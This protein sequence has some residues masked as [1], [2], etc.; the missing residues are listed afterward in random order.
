VDNKP[1]LVVGVNSEFRYLGI[2][3]SLEMDNGT[4][5][6]LI[7]NKLK[8]SLIITS[9]LMIRPQQ[10]L[11]LLK[12]IMYSQLFSEKKIYDFPMDW[13]DTNLDAMCIRYILYWLEMPISSCV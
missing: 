7:V 6:D 8:L 4:A 10:K 1:V 11:K 12:E 2:I 9:R 13:I 3:F 5:K